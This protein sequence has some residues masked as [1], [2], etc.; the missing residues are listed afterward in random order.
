MVMRKYE[1]EV[2]R[3]IALMEQ[4]FPGFRNDLDLRKLD[5]QSCEECVLGLKCGD[6]LDGL[7]KLGI[8]YLDLGNAEKMNRDAA[9]YGFSRL[10][11]EEGAMTAVESLQ[12]WQLLTEEWVRQLTEGEQTCEST[13]GK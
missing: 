3:G 8:Y 1:Q 13:K 4:Y 7:M 11:S 6:Y 5:M 9:Y 12:Q 10:L 2:A